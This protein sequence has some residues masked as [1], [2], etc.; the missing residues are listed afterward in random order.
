MAG[1]ST[2]CS[3]TE[4]EQVT[5]LNEVLDDETL[6]YS[7]DDD[8]AL[9]YDYTYV[10]PPEAISAIESDSDH[11]DIMA[12]DGLEEVSTRFV[13]DLDVSAFESIF[14]ISRVQLIV[15]EMHR[16]AQQEILKIARP[17]IS[18]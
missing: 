5:L 10:V 13:W 3:L 4:V 15:D 1:P 2:S 18:L 12:H 11:K 16:Y 17:H 9:D 6:S 8:S 7:S 14:N